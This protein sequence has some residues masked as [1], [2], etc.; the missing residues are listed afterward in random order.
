MRITIFR[1][2]YRVKIT[3]LMQGF[4][5]QKNSYLRFAFIFVSYKAKGYTLIF[6]IVIAIRVCSLSYRKEVMMKKRLFAGLLGLAIMPIS[7]FAGKSVEPEGIYPS[8]VC[9]R[10]FNP[11]GHASRCACPDTY[12]YEQ[13]AG[14]CIPKDSSLEE[15]E[16]E[17]TLRAGVV[18]IGGETT[19]VEL[20]TDQGSYELI[21]ERKELDTISRYDGLTVEVTGD[22]IYLP[23]VEKA[24]RPALIVKNILRK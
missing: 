23:K 1:I 3:G 17:G 4:L 24:S 13:R 10:D 15:I 2:N 11:W 22:L 7:S 5:I 16:T 18:A 19:G 6:I 8:G 20:I 9:T 21:L 12:Q 14:L